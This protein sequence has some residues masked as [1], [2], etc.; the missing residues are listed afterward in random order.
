MAKRQK[1]R[2]GT[3]AGTTGIGVTGQIQLSD[4][5]T[6]GS[7]TTD[8]YLVQAGQSSGLNRWL[9]LHSIILHSDVFRCCS[10]RMSVVI[11]LWDHRGHEL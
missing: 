5:V 7:G 9:G 2:A 1:S 11:A 8:V 10:Q 6:R 4:T 3:S